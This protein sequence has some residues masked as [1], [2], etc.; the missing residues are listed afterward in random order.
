MSTRDNAPDSDSVWFSFESRGDV[1][2]YYLFD[3][4]KKAQATRDDAGYELTI[5]LK[6]KD[7][8]EKHGIDQ[9]YITKCFATYISRDL[10]DPFPARIVT[11]IPSSNPSNFHRAIDKAAEMVNKWH[12]NPH[13]PYLKRTT[14][15]AS[16]HLGGSRDRSTH[17]RTIDAPYKGWIRGR[18]FLIIDDVATTC[19]SMEVC[20]QKLLSAGAAS[21]TC[22][23]FAKTF[24]DYNDSKNS[25]VFQ[26]RRSRAKSFL[27]LAKSDKR[28]RRNSGKSIYRST[29]KSKPR[30]VK[31]VVSEPNSVKGTLLEIR[32]VSA[33][34]RAFFST[35]SSIRVPD[36]WVN[37]LSGM[38]H[39]EIELGR[40]NIDR[41]GKSVPVFYA[42]TELTDSMEVDDYVR[43]VEYGPGRVVEVNEGS[44]SILFAR[45]LNR[46][47]LWAPCHQM[48]RSTEIEFLESRFEAGDIIG[49]AGPLSRL[50]DS[51]DPHKSRAYFEAAV[52]AGDL[53]LILSKAKELDAEPT[54]RA[55][56][57][58]YYEIAYQHGERDEAAFWLGKYYANLPVPDTEK[59][60]AY[61][62]AAIE[63][64]DDFASPNNLAILLE[65]TDR[66]QA[67]ELYRMAMSG[68]NLDKAPCNLGILLEQ[69][70]REEAIQLYETAISNGNVSTASKRLA[71]L[72]QNADISRAI[73]LYQMASDN[74][75][76]YASFALAQIVEPQD[77]QRAIALYES[78]ATI[79]DASKRATAL[80]K[81][82]YLNESDPSIA[83]PYY[84]AAIKAGDKWASA[85]NLALFY[86]SDDEERF[87]SLLEQS[88]EGGGQYYADYRLG[89]HLLQKDRE[90]AMRYLKSAAD[91]DNPSACND[92]AFGIQSSDPEEAIRYYRKGIEKG[93]ET[94]APYNLACML[95]DTDRDEAIRLFGIAAEH[96]NSGAMNRLALLLEE[97]DPE[98]A[99]SLFE[100]A[101]EAGDLTAS[102]NNLALF[103]QKNDRQRAIELYETAIANG[104]LYYAA[105]N[106][107]ELIQDDDR[108]K[109][110]DL[111][112][113]A[114]EAGN[115][116]ALYVIG[117]MREDIPYSII[118]KIPFSA[119]DIEDPEELLHLGI[120][121][122]GQKTEKALE[123]AERLFER[124]IEL[125]DKRASTCNL[126]MMISSRDPKRA[127]A[128]Y[129]E[130]LKFDETEAM[131]GL[132]WLLKEIDPERAKSLSD[133]AYSK[134]DIVESLMFIADYYAGI[135]DDR[136]MRLYQEAAERGSDKARKILAERDSS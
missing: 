97:S 49:S 71:D 17:E 128:L 88:H 103:I 76:K 54:C 121:W 45:D 58:K 135:D 42:R 38:V 109:A 3:Y 41:G 129:E 65:D 101:I 51:I 110:I 99:I 62:R 36:D 48:H 35:G 125:G 44:I 64:G 86:E 83:I 1:Q 46:R 5:A 134:S 122:M 43:H 19:S 27:A 24:D 60:I 53:D 55:E 4:V 79:S 2:I 95:V 67:I 102:T 31:P 11:T 29:P 104:D 74:G 115:Y 131:L 120:F 33:E 34:H 9:Q 82:G 63:Q 10:I 106:Y 22:A 136:A 72:L 94:Y 118:S 112:W 68:G 132:S 96:D 133:K 13:R 124:A 56:A 7:F 90:S 126:A 77:K 127:T 111:L 113:K 39:E 116:A 61:Y 123:N 25:D 30:P 92:Y 40:K 12:D 84:E 16:A 52:K 6:D 26:I 47:Q 108:A 66:E 15:V 23:V 21:V 78:A 81:L 87:F 100:Q 93:D 37:Y 69:T 50:Y 105:K 107:G 73:D 117:G 98:R 114:F 18:H 32:K 119:T 70:N 80:F 8:A 130:S 91:A 28:S 59:A 57:A 14:E 89:R 85:Y 75:N 20:R